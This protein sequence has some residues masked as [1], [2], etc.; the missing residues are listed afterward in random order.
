VKLLIKYPGD[1]LQTFIIS[2][3]T[4]ILF[5]FSANAR[6]KAD[7][8]LIEKG[9]R[10][11]SL[12]YG[13]HLIKSYRIALG[14]E[15]LGPKQMFGDSKTPEGVYKID[16][17]K[18]NSD[19]HLALRINYPTKKQRRA[20]SK[21]GLNPGGD[22]MIHGLHPSF[23]WIKEVHV[24]IDWTDGCIAVTN[25]EIEEIWDYVDYGTKVVITP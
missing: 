12:F 10:T 16:Y 25:A 17:K 8:V 24:L 22:I 20:A 13:Y 7:Y 6:I 5:T 9:A 3:V 15:P 19:F 14:G 11:L 2:L 23:A 4:S 21:R 1:A 18:E